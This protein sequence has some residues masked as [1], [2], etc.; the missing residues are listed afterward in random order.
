MDR[1]VEQLLERVAERQ[2]TTFYGKYR[3][4]VS[5]NDDPDGLGRI[6]AEV[7]AVLGAEVS[8]WAMPCLPFAGPKH[9]LA[10]IPEVGDG[11]WIEFEAG[12][13]NMPI[14]SGCWWADDQRPEP[15]G[16][17]QRLL[18][19][20]AG[21]QVLIDEEAD[22][23]RLVHPGGAELVLGKDAI[24]LTLGQA[25]IEM[26]SSEVIINDGM[27][28]ITTAGASLVNDAFKVGG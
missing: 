7:P 27:A 15:A 18:A 13:L 17:T 12:N 10:L 5:E 24:T 6:K 22:E 11:V 3:G 16:A 8:Q 19:T 4:L 14:W 9:G 1:D 20:S 26:S 21:H 2:R 28:K 23:I 25:K